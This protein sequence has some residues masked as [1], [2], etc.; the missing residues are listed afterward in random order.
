MAVQILNRPA[1][2][3]LIGKG[4]GEGI[5]KLAQ[6][7][8]ESL[9]KRRGLANL[10]P[11]KAPEDIKSL[12]D[13]PDDLLQQVIKNYQA[14]Q[15][16]Q[17]FAKILAGQG[18]QAGQADQAGQGVGQQVGNFDTKSDPGDVIG[19]AQKP[20]TG[21]QEPGISR[22]LYNAAQPPIQAK[23]KLNALLQSGML[24]SLNQHQ[25][26]M[27]IDT[28]FGQQKIA[29]RDKLAAQKEQQAAQK[30]ELEQ[31]R[32][33]ESKQA[34]IDKRYQKHLEKTDEQRSAL[35][36]EEMALDAIEDAMNSGKLPNEKVAQLAE[37]LPLENPA[38]FMNNPYAEQMQAALKG[39]LRNSRQYFGAR[40]VMWEIQQLLKGLP[41]IYNTPEGR[42]G[43]FNTI[44][45]INT[46]N[47]KAIEI[48]DK[49]IEE[50]NGEVPKNLIAKVEK[51]LKPYYDKVRNQVKTLRGLNMFN[52][53]LAK[54]RIPNIG[55]R[56]QDPETGTVFVYKE[57]GFAPE[58]G[59]DK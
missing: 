12:A 41:T 10:F 57:G 34:R 21:A 4:L 48:Q 28:L 17:S 59:F 29:D 54:G 31:E 23:D 45:S 27:A 6:G 19:A 8:M 51:E 46:I 26:K 25:Q 3:D 1:L 39:Y 38:A 53:Q 22:E 14:Q 16:A 7:K 32:F 58:G 43:I 55:K 18:G 30:Q 44:K 15:Q 20:P 50:N 56:I 52:K 9:Q 33:K 47:K 49:L 5:N 35:R 42:R 24:G 13:M 40:P 37:L 36:E 2:S 11:D